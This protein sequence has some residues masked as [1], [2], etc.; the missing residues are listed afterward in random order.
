[1]NI[2]F[3]NVRKQAL[4]AHDKLVEKMNSAIYKKD[5]YLELPGGRCAN[6]NGFVVI[7][8]KTID[9]DMNDLRMLLGA[10]ASTYE[11]GD[12]K[13]KDVYAEIYKDAGKMHVF[14]SDGEDEG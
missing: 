13:F 12:L 7:D 1:M 9:E 2:D 5:E 8:A 11:P 6:L 10:I 3:N 4:F 14:N